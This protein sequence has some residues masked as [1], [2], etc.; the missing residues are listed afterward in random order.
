MVG[1]LSPAV[2]SCH[3]LSPAGRPRLV[4]AGCQQLAMGLATAC[5]PRL[6][7]ACLPRTPCPAGAM[8]MGRRPPGWPAS[9]QLLTVPQ[10]RGPR[11][12][13]ALTGPRLRRGTPLTE[14]R[15]LTG[16]RPLKK[17]PRQLKGTR[18]PTELWP[19]TGPWRPTG[20]RQRT[21]DR[22]GGR[23][24][25]ATQGST[26]RN[27]RAGST[28]RRQRRTAPCR[29]PGRRRRAAGPAST[30]PVPA[31]PVQAG[32]LQARTT[33]TRA[34]TAAGS[35]RWPV[36]WLAGRQA[37]CQARHRAGR[38]PGRSWR[39]LASITRNHRTARPA[40]AAP[41]DRPDRRAFSRPAGRRTASAAS[42]DPA[43]SACSQV[44]GS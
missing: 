8:A 32:P 9:A 6:P 41:T 40:A 34:R 15:P 25:T 17:G 24:V 23:G 18:Q 2:A 27:G 19:L 36:T 16:P 7:T 39:T 10:P 28:A 26:P 21:G 3:R 29:P 12:G 35:P 44:R 42:P 37:N 20:P 11:R 22:S 5:R 13:Q 33:R 31:C 38:R 14:L 1:C 43:Y 30:G 4:M